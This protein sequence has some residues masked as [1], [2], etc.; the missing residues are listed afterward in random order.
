MT[1][2]SKALQESTERLRLCAA[3]MKANRLKLPH[4][5]TLVRVRYLAILAIIDPYRDWERLLPQTLTSGELLLLI[6]VN[7]APPPHPKGPLVDPVELV[8]MGRDGI[9]VSTGT[10]A[11]ADVL[12]PYEVL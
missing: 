1:D 12:D 2:I 7:T 4:P 9:L 3:R 8:F 11:A 10:R 5:G 6:Y